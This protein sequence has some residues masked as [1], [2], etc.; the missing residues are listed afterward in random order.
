MRLRNN[1]EQETNANKKK[2]WLIV[3]LRNV[4]M[5]IVAVIGIVLAAIG[6]SGDSKRK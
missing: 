4:G 5:F 1:P 6:L 3:I 2:N